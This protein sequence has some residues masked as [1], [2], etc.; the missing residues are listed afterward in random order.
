VETPEPPQSILTTN[1]LREL[2]EEA[3]PNNSAHQLCQSVVGHLFS[4]P[5]TRAVDDITLVI[6]K[7]ADA[8][9]R[10]RH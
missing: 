7:H 8:I 4:E 1:R 3:E 10:N 6:A 2:L 9:K 5:T